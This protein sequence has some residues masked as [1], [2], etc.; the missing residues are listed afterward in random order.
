MALHRCITA[1]CL[2]CSVMTAAGQTEPVRDFRFTV[3][4][5]PFLSLSNPAML[6]SF[7]G[8]MAQAEAR[9]RKDNGKLISLTESPDSWQAGAGAEAYKRTGERLAFYGKMAW[10]H[11]SGKDMGGQVLMD[12]AYNPVNFLESSPLT[13]GIKTRERYELAGGLSYRISPRWALG[14]QMN[15]T[16]ADQTKVRDPRFANVWMD[17]DLNA[18]ASFRV[19]DKLVLGASLQFRNTLEQVKGGIYGV[20]DQQY[21]VQTD[22]GGFFGTISALDGDY[23]YISVSNPR[24]MMN[25]FL[26]GALQ[27]IVNQRFSNEL[28]LRYR[29][30]Y[31]GRKSSST[32]TFFEFDGLEGGYK[33]KLLLPSGKNLQVVALDAWVASLTNREN[34]FQ[35]ITPS[36]QNT[37]VNYT[38]QDV[39][40]QRFRLEGSLSYTFH[41][42]VDRQGASLSLGARVD[43]RV[44][45]QTTTL[46][47]F[48]RKQQ[49]A[50]YSAD[51]Y[52]SKR[53]QAGPVRLTAELHAL[54]GGGFGTPKEDGSSASASSTSIKSYDDY[55]NLYFEYETALRAGGRLALT[56]SLPSL[57]RCLPYLTLWD[58]YLTLTSVPAYLEGRG[59]NVAGISFGCNF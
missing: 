7:D 18:G 13:K 40:L 12:P 36:G 14:F 29:T 31:Y 16:S 59:R 35:Y 41:K 4:N 21:F 51:L 33:G 50:T 58:R 44:T 23:N 48:T 5:H 9:F 55:L 3:D 26:V 22:K 28:Q 25:Y 37:V 32:A 45:A 46:F 54:L 2:L 38:G 1:F 53:F 57:G 8:L 10:Q 17:L 20:T 6:D 42:G 47:P 11:F 27:V 34:K 39:I 30:G 19:S 43:G 15:Y 52:A 24:P 49:V 56:C